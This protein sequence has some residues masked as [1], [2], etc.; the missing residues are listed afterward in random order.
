M[1]GKIKPSK[2]HHF[3]KLLQDKNLLQRMYTQNIDTLESKAGIDKDKLVEAHGSFSTA[4]CINCKKPVEDMNQ[5]WDTITNYKIPMCDSCNFLVRPDVVF[6]G[7]SP[8]DRFFQLHNEDLKSADLLIVMGTSLVVYPFASLVNMVPLLTP[9]VLFNKELVG[10]FQKVDS[11]INYRDVAFVGDCD[12][13]AET[14]VSLLSWE[15]EFNQIV[16]NSK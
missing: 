16:A 5:F 4:C 3:I 6:F 13:A 11:P 9:R 7:E 8:P 1:Q 14:L 2:T 15:E 12:T 10:P